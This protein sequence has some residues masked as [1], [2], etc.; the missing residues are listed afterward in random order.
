MKEDFLSRYKKFYLTSVY[1]WNCVALAHLNYFPTNK[2]KA[3]KATMTETASLY[4][5]S[6][7]VSI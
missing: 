1:M 6:V 7:A 2:C 4:L 5:V 3:T